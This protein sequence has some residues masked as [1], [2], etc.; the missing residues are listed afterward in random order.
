MECREARDRLQKL[1]EPGLSLGDDAALSEHLETCR[2]CQEFY[3]DQ[4]IGDQLRRLEMPEPRPD[5]ADE[6]IRRARVRGYW[7]RRRITVPL[8]AAAIILIAAT[9]V[10]VGQQW[11]IT[12][13]T[14]TEIVMTTDL[15]KTVRVLIEAAAE[16]Q[17]ATLTIDLAENLEIKG[18]PN[19]RQLV[20][21]ADLK[22]GRNLLALPVV[23]REPGDG[24]INIGYRY[25]DRS[26]V[27]RITVRGDATDATFQ[28]ERS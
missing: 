25:G 7:T 17:N 20:W 28:N 21:Q 1:L 5:F 10:L 18:Y 22:Q 23:L 16:R 9:V 26:Q 15:E 14:D 27:V 11:R 6:A 19:R 3:E 2:S 4:M 13:V 8:A 12:G 24:Y